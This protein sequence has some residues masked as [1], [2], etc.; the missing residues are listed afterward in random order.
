ML[1]SMVPLLCIFIFNCVNAFQ[2]RN[3]STS[4]IPD[5]FNVS[6]DNPYERPE[7]CGFNTETEIGKKFHNFVELLRSL[8]IYKQGRSMLFNTSIDN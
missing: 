5:I 8:C 1:V 7:S 3:V 2:G 4:L 6:P